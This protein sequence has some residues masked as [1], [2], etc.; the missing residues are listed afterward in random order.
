VKGATFGRRK[1][2][3]RLGA[4][5]LG[6]VRRA[7]DNELRREVA[8]SSMMEIADRRAASRGDS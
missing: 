2:T 5:S 1:V 7:T 4:G 8:R 3:A 6:D